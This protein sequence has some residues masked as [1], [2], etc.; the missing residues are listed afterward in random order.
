MKLIEGRRCLTA[1]SAILLKLAMRTTSSITAS[2]STLSFAIAAKAPSRS[3]GPRAWNLSNATFS[4]LGRDLHGL[5]VLSDCGVVRIREDR[6]PA[7]ARDRIL[8]QLEPFRHE[9]GNEERVAGDVAARAREAR[10]DARSNGVADVGHDHRYRIRR[11]CLLRGE[12]ARCR[13]RHDDIHLEPDELGGELGKTVVLT[14]G[15][16]KLDDDILALDVTQVAQ[17]RPE[18]IDAGGPCRGRGHSQKPD[19]R[20]GRGRLLGEPRERRR[21][22]R[23]RGDQELSASSLIQVPS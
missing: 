8:E 3:A 13:V 23:A 1:S 7:H 17:S 18:C 6:H 22:E 10:D 4:V 5:E 2:A 21:Q 14:F 19:P 15:K 9:L 20:D 11:G 16:A 12:G